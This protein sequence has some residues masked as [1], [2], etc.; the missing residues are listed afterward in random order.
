MSVAGEA[1]EKVGRGKGRRR[2]GHVAGTSRSST[3][4]STAGATFDKKNAVRCL[5]ELSA[6]VME[7]QEAARARVLNVLG[8]HSVPDVFIYVVDGVRVNPLYY[9]P[10]YTPF[11]LEYT[12]LLPYIQPMYTRYTHVYTPHIY[13]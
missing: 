4:G 12:P 11:I 5:K 10:L 9:I 2:G 6:T 13:T 3:S 8:D 7:V 1:E